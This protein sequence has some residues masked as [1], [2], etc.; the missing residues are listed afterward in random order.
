MGHGALFR[1]RGPEVLDGWG[2]GVVGD[3][4]L[5]YKLEAAAMVESKTKPNEVSVTGFLEAVGDEGRRADAKALLKL[6]QNATKE[7][8]KMW[9]PA[10]VGFGSYHYKYESGR[11]GDAPLVGFSPRKA[12]LVLYGLGSLSALDPADPLRTRLGK[13]T[14]GKGCVYIKKLADVD[15]K[16]LESVIAKCMADARKKA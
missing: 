4:S 3:V 8:P 2:L 12:A 7:K 6:M 16:V 10:I 13:H 1:G 5:A 11:E 14:T 15:A 9:G